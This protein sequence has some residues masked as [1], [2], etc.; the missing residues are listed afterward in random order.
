M[1]KGACKASQKRVVDSRQLEFASIY[2]EAP[3]GNCKLVIGIL[4]TM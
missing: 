2:V 4:F 3:V 1:P